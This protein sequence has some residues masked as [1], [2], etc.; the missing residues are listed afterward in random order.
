MKKHLLWISVAALCFLAAC[1]SQTST[2]ESTQTTLITAPTEEVTP[3]RPEPI[4]STTPAGVG[5][6]LEV[7]DAAISLDEIAAY[8]VFRVEILDSYADRFIYAWEYSFAT[9]TA[10]IYIYDEYEG[11]EIV[12]VVKR[13]K[14]T[15]YFRLIGDKEFILDKEANDDDWMEDKDGINYIFK[16]LT[17]FSVPT[18]GVTYK[19]LEDVKAVAGDACA[20][21]VWDNG[22]L[23][24]YVHI[25][26]A[27]GIMSAWLDENGKALTD[28]TN[29]ST[30]S[31]DIPKYK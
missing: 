7:P 3:T 15:R 28:I 31:A 1:G 6:I 12:N 27:T 20:Y 23:T 29:I 22:V 25:D 8:E 2:P 16:T 19:K 9:D 4:V 14:A 10:V 21:E 26:K 24:G 17:Q 11:E 30:E 5:E 18:E 13:D